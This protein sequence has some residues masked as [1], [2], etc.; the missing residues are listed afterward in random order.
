MNP[1]QQSETQ[2]RELAGSMGETDLHPIARDEKL[3]MNYVITWLKGYKDGFVERLFHLQP[4]LTEGYSNM[5]TES[6]NLHAMV[7]F[8][9]EHR[10]ELEAWQKAFPNH[11]YDTISGK[12]QNDQ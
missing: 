9:K 6:G 7:G 10:D 8:L 11:S 4:G 3:T 12:I 2:K 5:M 1:S